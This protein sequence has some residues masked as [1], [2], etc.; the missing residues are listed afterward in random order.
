MQGQQ[1]STCGE[2]EMVKTSSQQT[3]TG[4]QIHTPGGAT[5]GF[6]LS[7][8]SRRNKQDARLL[9]LKLE[10]S[11]GFGSPETSRRTYRP[12]FR[13]AFILCCS[14]VDRLGSQE[15][16]KRIDCCS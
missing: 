13:K 3:A 9:L 14:Y 16:T 11:E 6:I 7:A 8:E 4:C 10:V 1:I 12:N 15:R 5:V 2:I